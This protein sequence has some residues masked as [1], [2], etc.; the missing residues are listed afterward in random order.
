MSELT[1]SDVLAMT[2]G[3][4]GFLE[5]NGIIILILFFLMLGGGGLFGGNSAVQGALTRAEL[6]DGLNAQSVQA[7]MAR[8][9][10]NINNG[11]DNLMVAMNNGFAGVQLG[12]NNGFNNLMAAINGGVGTINS[13]LANIGYQLN[14]CCTDL[15]TAM[16]AEA[17]MT[18]ALLNQY[19]MQALR[20][21][22]ADKDKDILLANLSA[23][24]VAQTQQLEEYIASKVG[25]TTTA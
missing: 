11:F 17:E 6:Y 19:E 12:M 2:R 3:K 4:D 21:K 10:G 23:S 5:G 13:N 1:A 8:L 9:D 24:Q 14:Q 25:T 20:D 22:L 18:R 16:H 15:K 7:E